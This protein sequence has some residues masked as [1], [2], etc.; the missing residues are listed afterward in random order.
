MDKIRKFLRK[1]SPDKQDEID[2]ILA[3]IEAGE[4]GEL[5]IKKLTGFVNLYRIRK[6]RVRV[7]FRID[8]GGIGRV[9]SVGFK[10]DNSYKGL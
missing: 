4:T 2:K 5:K 8:E 10:D 7:I 6:G 1:L 9:I 3:Q